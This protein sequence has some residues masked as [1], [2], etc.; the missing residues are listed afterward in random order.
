MIAKCANPACPV[1]FHHNRGGKFLRFRREQVAGKEMDGSGAV[2]SGF[3]NVEHFWLCQRCCQFLTLVY[4]EGRGVV[5]KV[6]REEQPTADFSG[7][8]DGSI[9]TARADQCASA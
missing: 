6:E 7:A 8:T 1:Q 3:H 9:A 2:Q 4:I 5:L